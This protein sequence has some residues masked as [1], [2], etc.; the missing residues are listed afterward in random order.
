MQAPDNLLLDEPTNHLD[1]AG[2]EWLETLL[3]QRA[4]RLRRGQPRSL[5][6]GKRRHRNGRA[7]SRLRRRLSARRGKLQHL[8]RSEGGSI[9]TRR[10]KRQEALENRVHTEIEWLRRGPKARTTKSKARIDNAHEMIGELAG[11]QTRTRTD[12]RANRFFRHRPPNQ[13]LDRTRR[14]H[15]RHRRPQPV[16]RISISPSP[17][18]C[19]WAWSV[20]TAA[21]RPRCCACCAAK[22]NRTRGAIRKADSLRIVYFDQNREL[23]P[24]I[25]LRRALAPDSDSVIYQDRVIHVAAWADRFLFDRE[26]LNQ[27]RRHDFPAA[28]ARAC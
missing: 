6:S 1:L 13:A 3:A 17:P 2:I 25:T 5:F 8:S 10:R 19:A 18:E 12:I 21:A 7:E 22:L 24:D 16:R 9:C 14:R 20:P 15:L 4:V 26:Q 23:D 11:H 28:S 27:P